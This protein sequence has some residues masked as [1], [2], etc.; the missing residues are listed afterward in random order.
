MR[1][2]AQSAAIPGG[3]ASICNAAARP[4]RVDSPAPISVTQWTRGKPQESHPERDFYDPSI[5]PTEETTHDAADGPHDADAALDL[6]VG[7]PRGPAQRRYGDRQ[8]AG[9]RRSAPHHLGT[10]RKAGEAG[11]AGVRAARL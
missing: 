8:Q 10:S 4:Y 2:K 9:R 3:I 7:P 11:G 6:F 1:C 5:Q